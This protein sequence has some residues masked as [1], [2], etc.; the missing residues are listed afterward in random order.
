MINTHGLKLDLDALEAV[1]KATEDINDALVQLIYFDLETGE[2]IYRC[3]TSGNWYKFCDPSITQICA[4]RR[5][6]SAQELAD[7]IDNAMWQLR[8]YDKTNWPAL[9]DW[10]K[11]VRDEQD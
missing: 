2:A 4:T 9:A 7:E 6:M 5:H 3:T 1:S 8:N 11:E 10:G